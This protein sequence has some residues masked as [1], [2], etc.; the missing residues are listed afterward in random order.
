MSALGIA[1]IFQTCYFLAGSLE[2]L[3]DADSFTDANVYL[4]ALL[5]PISLIPIKIALK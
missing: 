1:L 4:T 5:L 3:P 2:L